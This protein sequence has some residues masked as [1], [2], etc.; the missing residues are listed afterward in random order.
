MCLI[1]AA[2]ADTPV[3]VVTYKNNLSRTGEN[4]QETI[5]TPA[6][7]NAEQFG[8]IRSFPVDGQIYAQPLYLASVPIPDK[9]TRNVVFVATEHNSVYAFDADCSASDDCTL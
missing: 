4:L 8:K 2:G 7:V 9:G 3:N 5:L 6:N 1:L